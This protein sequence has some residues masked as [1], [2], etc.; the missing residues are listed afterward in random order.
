[1]RLILISDFSKCRDVRVIEQMFELGLDR[2]HIREKDEEEVLR[3]VQNIGVK[4]QNKLSYHGN[5]VSFKIASHGNFEEAKSESCHTV[6]EVYQSNKEYV[7]LSPIFNS[8]SKSGYVSKFNLDGLK[9]Q[10]R[11]VSTRVYALGGVSAENIGLLEDSGF[12][13]AAVKG[14]VWECGASPIN[15]FKLLLNRLK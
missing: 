10:L 1:M 6:K 2:F 11:L 12:Y 15:Q 13:G 3:F 7:F 9:D 5:G 4:Y 8:I 14:F